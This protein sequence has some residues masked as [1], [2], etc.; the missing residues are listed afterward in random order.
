MQRELSIKDP[1]EPV[2]KIQVIRNDEEGKE[3]TFSN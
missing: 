1:A 3:A 2:E